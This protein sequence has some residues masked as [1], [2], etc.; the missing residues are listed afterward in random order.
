MQSGF[1]YGGWRAF[2]MVLAL[3]LAAC[4]G[5]D[6]AEDI[7]AKADVSTFKGNGI[8][9]N[10]SES[11]SGFFFE[12]QGATGV[13]T[14]Y[15]YETNGRPVWYSAAGPF[16]GSAD[17]KFQFNGTLLRYSGGQPA[18]STVAKTP[19]STSAGTTTITFTGETAVV[20]LPGRTFNAQKFNK[21][22]QFTPA[23]GIQ[24]ETG[25]YWN[26]DQSGRGYVIEVANGAATV[27][28]FH[29]A[30][31]GQ[32]TWNLVV[33][34][35]PAAGQGAKGTFTAYSGGQTL[36][37]T[38][39]AP[40]STSQGTFAL[41]FGEPCN[42]KLGFPNMSPVAVKRFAFGSLAAG[43]ECRTP[44][45]SAPAVSYFTDVQLTLV[46]PTSIRSDAAKGSTLPASFRF[47]AAGNIASLNGK[48]IYVVV[49]D[50]EGFYS[51][52][53][54]SVTV[55]PS[56]GAT[57]FLTAVPL[58]RTGRYTGNIRIFGCLNSTCTSQFTGSPFV[59]PY[60]FTAR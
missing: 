5:G 37:G 29:Y 30:D 54:P 25:I 6:P 52:A 43:A 2:G 27:A 11:G 15:A 28:V 32:P 12:A 18:S 34:P 39:K 57:I 36:S 33:A 35:M 50:P 23:N 49:E 1:W 41:L 38:Y 58:Q 42:G 46:S 9:W 40:T 59:V 14:F 7:A 24:P 44:T 13:V 48:T 10:P 31:D 55:D 60:D 19:V 47:S 17:G 3:A 21:A 53:N 45:G 56:P 16:T 8:W 4:G 51:A 22:G 20:Q 26:P